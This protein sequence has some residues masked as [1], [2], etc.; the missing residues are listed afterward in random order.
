MKRSII[1]G[2]VAVLLCGLSVFAMGIEKKPMLP[3]V[4]NK[5]AEVEKEKKSEEMETKK[6]PEKVVPK[7]KSETIPAMKQEEPS[8]KVE[9]DAVENTYFSDAVFIGDSRT[10]GFRLH[11]GLTEAGY[12]TAK[13]L[14]VK[15]VFEKPLIKEN[16]GT[17]TIAQALRERTYQKYYIMLGANELG[18]VYTDIFTDKYGQIID[19]IREVNPNATIYVQSILPVTDEKSQSDAIY[20]NTNIVRFNELLKVLA[21]E[22]SV[23]YLTVNE[24]VQKEDGALQEEATT[25]GVHLNKEYCVKWLEYLKKHIDQNTLEEGKK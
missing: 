25:D 15:D 22:K 7:E 1:I 17:K 6:P 3:E 8:S 24:A 9:L 19:L 11:A 4:E 2:V 10:E 21:Q 5:P 13:G 20:N 18:W 12:L 16:N 23:I 14:N